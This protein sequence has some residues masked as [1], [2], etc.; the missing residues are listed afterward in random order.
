MQKVDEEVRQGHPLQLQV[1]PQ[2][3]S[4]FRQQP[5]SPQIQTP[6]GAAQATVCMIDGRLHTSLLPMPICLTN[7]PMGRPWHIFTHLLR[8]CVICV[9]KAHSEYKASVS[10]AS[11]TMLCLIA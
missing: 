11:Y 7:A 5:A 6:A 9:A 8:I 3:E 4:Q 2:V 1:S 10:R